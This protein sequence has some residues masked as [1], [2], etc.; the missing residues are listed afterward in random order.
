MITL[1]SLNIGDDLVADK[2]FWIV[3]KKNLVGER[4]Y[5]DLFYSGSLKIITVYTAVPD[6]FSV[7][8]I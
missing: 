6:G 2:F 8:R 3:L 7:I 4:L 1:Q 5:V